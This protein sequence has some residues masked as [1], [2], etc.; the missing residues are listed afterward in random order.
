MQRTLF[1]REEKGYPIDT[2]PLEL[3]EIRLCARDERVCGFD[4]DIY[5]VLKNSSLQVKFKLIELRRK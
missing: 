5:I 1:R 3:G 4:W 2:Q